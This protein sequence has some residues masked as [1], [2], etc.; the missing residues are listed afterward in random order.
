MHVI[1]DIYSLPGGINGQGVEEETGRFS[2]YNN[3]TALQYSYD[4]VTAVI[5][6]I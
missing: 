2:W 4:A 3:M 1:I 6:F 5:S